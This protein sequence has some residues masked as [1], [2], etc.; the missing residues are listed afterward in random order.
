MDISQAPAGRMKSEPMH[1]LLVDEPEPVAIGEIPSSPLTASES[2]ALAPSVIGRG[3]RVT[4][5]IVCHQDLFVEGEVDGRLELPDHRLTIGPRG[6]VKATIKAQNVVIVGTA[7][8]TIEA[9]ERVELC[10]Q[11]RLVGDIKT[12][13][14]VIKDGA[15]FK[16]T[17][18]VV[19]KTP[20]A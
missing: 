3:V 5:E 1:T 4:G 16:G 18:D 19:R 7:E 8:A 11:C 13:R 20:P 2:P 6:N 15:H 10:S 14:I 9:T 12:P 17:I